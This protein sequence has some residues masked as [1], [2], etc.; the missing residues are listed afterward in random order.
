[1]DNHE[2]GYVRKGVSTRLAHERLVP[3]WDALRLL[4]CWGGPIYHARVRG[5]S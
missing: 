2:L 3:G 4:E 5:P 1:M